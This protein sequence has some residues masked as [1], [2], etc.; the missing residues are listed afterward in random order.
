MAS[1][2]APV[3]IALIGDTV[4]SRE[5]APPARA[6]LQADLEAAMGWINR[7]YKDAVLSNF[8]ITLGDEFQ[9][10]LR[11]PQV[12]PDIIQDL[13]EQLPHTSFRIAVSKGTLSTPLKRVALGT[14]GPAWH[15]ARALLGDWLRAKR[16]G[17]GFAGFGGDD[18]VLNAFG[19]LLTYHWTHLESTQREILVSLRHADDSR[20]A[21]AE[22]IGISQQSLSNRAQ[23]AGWREYSQ[24]MA[25]WS[26]VLAKHAVKTPRP[27]GK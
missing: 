21:V 18:L 9:G 12:I 3:V 19:G 10:I 16:D 25:A 24:A 27:R 13:R 1:N 26:A 4:Q 15:A 6:A 14:D 17:I 20:K 5:I 23:S 8:L 2:R 7:Q 22:D 11:H